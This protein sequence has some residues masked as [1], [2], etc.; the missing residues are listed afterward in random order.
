MSFI[1]SPNGL[2]SIHYSAKELD[3][4]FPAPASGLDLPTAKSIY[5]A[6]MKT[7]IID[8]Y[9]MVWVLPNSLSQIL[10]T[11]KPN[12]KHIVDKIGKQYK[13]KGTCT[14]LKLTK[15]FLKSSYLQDRL[16]EKAMQNI[17]NRS[18]WLFATQLKQ[19]TNA[20]RHTNH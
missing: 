18:A 11:S 12:A 7:A 10:R 19:S 5:N 17:P 2:I 4:E 6:W 15:D 16:S 1:S 8:N 13:S 3:I 14:M 9:G 20:L